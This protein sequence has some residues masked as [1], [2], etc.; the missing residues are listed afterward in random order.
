M[1]SWLTLQGPVCRSSSS[2][3]DPCLLICNFLLQRVHLCRQQIFFQ[4]CQSSFLCGIFVCL[5][6]KH[7]RL[8]LG[9]VIAQG[10]CLSLDLVETLLAEVVPVSKKPKFWWTTP[11]PTAQSITDS[12]W[13]GSHQIVQDM[14]K[15][16]CHKRSKQEVQEG[17]QDSRKSSSQQPV[18]ILRGEGMGG[19][20]RGA[21]LVKAKAS[22]CWYHSHWKGGQ[23]SHMDK[24]QDET[25]I[26]DNTQQRAEAK[27]R[28][29]IWTWEDE[30]QQ[31]PSQL[32]QQE[33]NKQ[34]LNGK[35]GAG[36]CQTGHNTNTEQ[37][38]TGKHR[39]PFGC[40]FKQFILKS[41]LSHSRKAFMGI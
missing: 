31:P 35:T 5:V 24:E 29:A 6:D 34:E 1:S 11:F 38:W 19:G 23:T 9:G 27:H 40:S 30:Q 20:F 13:V 16:G 36:S 22:Q 21:W 33:Q 28:L 15:A 10:Y 8:W 41:V 4:K 7:L 32:T 25:N 26:Q 12:A 39:Q 3:T 2:Q 17:A 18:M 37:I 14:G